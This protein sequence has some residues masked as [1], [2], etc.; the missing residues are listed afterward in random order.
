MTTR[1][2]LK[3]WFSN[4]KKPNQNHFWAWLDS[5]IHKEDKIPM[6]SI[7][8]LDKA[9]QDTASDTQFQSHLTDAEAH[10]A[11][12]AQK[13]D[14]EDGKGLS[15]NDYS[16]EEKQKV[17]NSADKTVVNLT[18]TGDVDKIAT[19]TFADGTSIKASFRDLGVENVADIMLNSLNFNHE[20]GVLTGLRSDGQQLTVNL[21]GRY[22]LIGHTHSYNDLE[23]KPELLPE[24]PSD[25]KEYLRHNKAWKA[26]TGWQFKELGL[27]NLNDIKT[28]G[29]YGKYNSSEATTARNYPYD[30]IRGGHLLVLPMTTNAGTLTVFQVYFAA[31]TQN[32]GDYTNSARIFMRAF[33]NNS[34]W[35]PWREFDGG[36]IH[37][38]TAV[39]QNLANA[40]QNKFPSNGSTFV[41]NQA[42]TIT[43]ANTT[44][45]VTYVKNT[46]DNLTFKPASGV[47]II[48]DKVVT[49]P[50]GTL[51]H[52]ICNGTTAFVCYNKPQE[53]G[54]AMVI[55]G[56]TALDASHVGRV[57]QFNN[58]SNINI[59]ISNLPAGATVSGVKNNTGTITFTGTTAPTSD[60]VLN[61]AVNSSFS[62]IKNASGTTNL[63]ISNK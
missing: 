59:D 56:N 62:L 24:A 40:F 50:V 13:V 39:T 30:P 54:F 38:L 51:V 9:L 26:F 47:E 12:F 16:D 3:N 55:A 22:S 18:I 29:F 10:Q 60:N 25:G 27:E 32:S 48:G 43:V 46:T 61:G 5:F 21:D 53:Q 52:L 45:V 4:L 31:G 28:A 23:D 2:Q 58:A 33:V 14:K 17:H 1:E 20:T 42:T 6:E 36:K 34:H 7:E 15:T 35:L 19:I 63:L 41:V 11:L 44:Q 8:G 49:A 57:L 37:N